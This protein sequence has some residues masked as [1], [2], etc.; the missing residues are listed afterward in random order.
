M[1]VKA[2]AAFHSLPHWHSKKGGSTRNPSLREVYWF[3][4]N[5]QLKGVESGFK[6]SSVSTLNL[7]PS[8]PIWFFRLLSRLRPGCSEKIKLLL[9]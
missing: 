6:L 4:Q 5:H 2:L 8:Q 3:I 1:P 9:N 7:F